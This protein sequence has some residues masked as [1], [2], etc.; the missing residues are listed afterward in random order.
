MRFWLIIFAVVVVFYLLLNQSPHGVADRRPVLDKLMHPLDKRVRYRI[1]QVDPRFGISEQ[2]LAELCKQAVAI[3]EQG[4]GKALFVQDDTAALTI[5]LIYDERQAESTL[6]MHVENDLNHAQANQQQHSSQYQQQRQ[7]LEQERREIDQRQA[8]LQQ[9]YD[10]YNRIVEDW[11][12]LGNIDDYNRQLLEQQR[13][14]LDAEQR[15]LQQAIHQFNQH[16]D[17]VNRNAYQLNQEVSNFNQ[18]VAEYRRRFSPRQFEK[19]VFN[20]RQINIYEFSSP[21]EL[22]IVL[23]HEL[24][25]ALGLKHNNAPYSLMYPVL[26]EQ[27]I[28]DFQLTA[29]DKAML[30][31]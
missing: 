30:S 13:A 11:R 16:A 1:G 25:H 27:N 8:A 28:D 15:D 12:V 24:G 4:S 5:N 10:H 14:A 19:G 6:K 7:L 2:Q 23:A 22:K 31:R 20:G 29:A 3:W 18:S 26:Q 17:S 21:A 9:R